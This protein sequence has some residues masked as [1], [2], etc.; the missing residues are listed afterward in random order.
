MSSWPF[1]SFK[2]HD[3]THFAIL[4][5]HVLLFMGLVPVNVKPQWGEYPRPVMSI[6]CTSL[7]VPTIWNHLGSKR[8]GLKYCK[9]K[10]SSE[11][12]NK[13]VL[14]LPQATSF[15][16]SLLYG[17]LVDRDRP[18]IPSEHPWV[19][20]LLHWRISQWRLTDTIERINPP[21]KIPYY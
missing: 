7:A 19:A 8:K 15:L 16:A 18:W 5:L 3:Y 21:M 10:N 17:T 11:D 14:L 13:I 9:N 2:T 1:C 4:F 20:G 6:G 12:T